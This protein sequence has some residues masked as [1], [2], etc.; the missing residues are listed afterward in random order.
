MWTLQMP[1]TPSIEK[2]S[3]KNFTQQVT[4]YFNFSPLF[5]LF[6]PSKFPF[7]KPSLPFGRFAR[8]PLFGEHMLRQFIRQDSFCIGPLLCITMFCEGISLYF[9]FTPTSLAWPLLFFFCYWTFFFQL[10]FMGFVV[11]PCKCLAWS[12]FDLHFGFFLLINFC[13]PSNN[14]KILGIPVIFISFSLSFLQD[15][16]DKDVHHVD[17]LPRLGDVQITFEVPFS[18]FHP[19]KLYIYFSHVIDLSTLACHFWHDQPEGLW[20]IHGSSVLDCP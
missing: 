10:A 3:F 2:S 12:S 20:E 17:A 8:H 16:F 6:M 4:N 19:K 9:S 7:F 14:I 13:C 18:M 5:N 11:Q 1:L 15:T